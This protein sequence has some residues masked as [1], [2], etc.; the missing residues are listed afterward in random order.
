MARSAQLKGHDAA[1]FERF[2]EENPHKPGR[3]NARLVESG[4]AVW[5]FA[6]AWEAAG[7]DAARV[8]EDYELSLAQVEAAIRYYQRYKDII[9]DRRA[10]NRLQLVP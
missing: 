2:I 1:L 9:D 10:A 7:F 5:A 6:G 3:A 4:M 8:A